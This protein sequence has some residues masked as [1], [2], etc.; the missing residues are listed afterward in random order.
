MIVLPPFHL[1]FLFFPLFWRLIGLYWKLNPIVLE[2]IVV[3]YY[4]IS[5]IF[6]FFQ[7]IFLMY[8]STDGS[9]DCGSEEQLYPVVVR[10][11]DTDLHQNS[12]SDC[13]YYQSLFNVFLILSCTIRKRNKKMFNTFFSACVKYVNNSKFIVSW[14]IIS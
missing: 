1:F 5:Y 3:H 7:I 6:L 10:Y 11:Y 14:M 8:I 9:S 4:W 2:T 12:G 13:Q